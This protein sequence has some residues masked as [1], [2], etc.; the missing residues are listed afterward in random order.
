MQNLALVFFWGFHCYAKNY[1]D[2]FYKCHLAF[3][4]SICCCTMSLYLWKN[5]NV[6]LHSHCYPGIN[7]LG[8]FQSSYCYLLLI[9]ERRHVC[10]CECY[11][12][13]GWR[14]EL[15]YWDYN[16]T[17]KDLFSKMSELEKCLGKYCSHI[18]FSL[19]LRSQSFVSNKFFCDSD[20]ISMATGLSSRITLDFSSSSHK[21][22]N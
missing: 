9:L 18:K 2:T 7:A 4:Q 14:D 21:G 13:M 5:P 22:H 6:F 17:C 20:I 8:F 15:D 10:V 1:F 11:S 19:D 12:D 16:K 3:S